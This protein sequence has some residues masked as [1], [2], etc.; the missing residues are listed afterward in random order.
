MLDHEKPSVVYCSRP[1]GGIYEIERFETPDGGGTWF[2]YPVTSGSTMNN[3]RPGV[4]R[5]HIPGGI[6]VLWMHG[7]YIHYTDY[8]TSIR[9]RRSRS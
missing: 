6:E 4:P 9:F 3:I 8:R 7:G 2:S 1:V 5:G